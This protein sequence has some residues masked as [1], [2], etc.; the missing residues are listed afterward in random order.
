MSPLQ[1]PDL[2]GAGL[3]DLSLR[4]LTTNYV[5]NASSRFAP[6][7]EASSRQAVNYIVRLAGEKARL[8]RA[9]PHMLRHSCGYY[10]VDQGT[11]LRTYRSLCPRRG[12]PV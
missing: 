1:T 6:F 12:S 8:G 5:A 4:P 9:W 10:L 2:I 7:H 11:D 3:P